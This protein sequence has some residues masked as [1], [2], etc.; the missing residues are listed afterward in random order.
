MFSDAFDGPK[1]VLPVLAALDATPDDVVFVGD[2]DHD[3]AIATAAGVPFGLAGWNPRARS[4]PGD[5]VLAR[6]SDVLAF[7]AAPPLR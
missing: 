2:T 3:R 4:A 5:V 6:P 1:S 7:C